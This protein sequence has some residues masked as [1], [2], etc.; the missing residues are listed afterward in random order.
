MSRYVR[1]NDTDYKL[2]VNTGGTI[3]LDTGV[4]AGLVKI[5]GD[6]L[7]LG[8][9][10]TVNTT[11][12]IVEDN[13]IVINSGETGAGVTEGTAGIQIKRGSLPDAELIFDEGIQWLDTQTGL[14]SLGAYVFK[15]TQNNLIGIRTN[16]ITT[17]GYDLNLIGS[18][19]AVI[20]VTGTTD[21]E[22]NITDDDDIPNVKW[23]EDYVLDYFDTFPPYQ[24]KRG[25]SVLRMYDNNV[26]GEET[27]LQLTLNDVLS[28][29]FR[30][31]WFEVQD[32]RIS[33]NTIASLSSNSDLVLVAPGTGNVVV[34][35]VLRIKLAASAPT[36]STDGVKLYTGNEAQ[37]GTGV[38]FVNT[39][40]TK[41]E[42]VSKRKALAYSMIF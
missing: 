1:V 35:D 28:A 26:A 34:D 7:V 33:L 19:N 31:E 18:G 9:T 38:Y 21:Y 29:E 37:G 42:L 22:L 12:L 30:P 17:S 40:S 2:T 24:I 8:E 39:R 15:N 10:T 23:V 11:N 20:N 13:V 16:S 41:D 27:V 36:S 5:T 14:S 25:D 3:T 4:A 32:V 6:L